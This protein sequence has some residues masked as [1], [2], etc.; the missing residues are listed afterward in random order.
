MTS[1]AHQRDTTATPADAG[2][3]S[4]APPPTPT[5]TGTAPASDETST[6]AAPAPT[7]GVPPEPDEILG[8][9]RGDRW[10]VLISVSLIAL[11]MLAHWIRLTARG[12]APIE[13][14]RLDARPYQF[15]IDVNHAT[16]VE[17][18]QLE[19]IGEALG[20]RIVEDRE[21]HG[22]FRNVEDVG[23]VRG[24]GAKTLEQIRP[25]LTCRDCESAMP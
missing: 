16:W 7:V 21:Q 14:D 22:P 15:Q 19:G 11:L 10:F 5:A 4:V 3:C 1:G 12:R 9:T 20:R 18:M 13:I 25:Y 24:I 2:V 17:W 6:P 8:L 23:R